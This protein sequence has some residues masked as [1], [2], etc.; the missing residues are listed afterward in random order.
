MK[1]IV[2]CSPTSSHF[3]SFLTLRYENELCTTCLI[4]HHCMVMQFKSACKAKMTIHFKL[5]THGGRASSQ[6]RSWNQQ[7]FGIVT[8]KKLK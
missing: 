1:I 5:I 6:L 4:G 7:M 2:S 3:F 8:G